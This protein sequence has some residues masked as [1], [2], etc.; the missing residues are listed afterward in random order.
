MSTWF[1][2]SK[3]MTAKSLFHAQRKVL[4][5]TTLK[6]RKRNK[7]SLKLNLSLFANWLRMY[8]VTKLRRLWLA[9][10][11]MNHPA[12]LLHLNMVG[13]LIWNVSWKLKL[14][15]TT[16]WPATW[17]LRRLWKSIQTMQSF[18]N[19]ALKLKLTKATRLLRTLFGS[20][21]RHPFLHQDSPLKTQANLQHVFTEWLS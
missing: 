15:A 21:T 18:Q 1:N 16:A 9:H 7:K 12:Y 3:S 13:L 14:S 6:M 17:C 19:S 4:I 2:N 11:L 10:V 20:S 8:L 5:S